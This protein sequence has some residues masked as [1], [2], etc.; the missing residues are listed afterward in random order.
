MNDLIKELR[1]AIV[2]INHG[3]TFELG[4]GLAFAVLLK[5]AADALEINN[6]QISLQ[7]TVLV[8]IEDRLLTVNKRLGVLELKEANR[9]LGD[10]VCSNCGTRNR[11][12]VP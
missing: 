10:L 5:R 4:G 7:E 3:R 9:W 12:T 1:N 8:R 11:I 2:L 6:E